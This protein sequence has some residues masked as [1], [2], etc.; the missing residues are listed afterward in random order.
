MTA[1]TAPTLELGAAG[2][3]VD[4]VVNDQDASQGNLVEDAD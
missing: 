2:Q 3:Q 4:L 1:V